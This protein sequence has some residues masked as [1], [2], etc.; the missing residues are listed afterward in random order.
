MTMFIP[1]PASTG[2][3]SGTASASEKSIAT[4]ACG[5]DSGCPTLSTSTV[6]ATLNS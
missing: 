3:F 4:S 5:H 2:K 1:R 6:P